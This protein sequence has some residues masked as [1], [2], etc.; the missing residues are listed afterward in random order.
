MVYVITSMTSPYFTL[1]GTAEWIAEKRDYMTLSR[2]KRKHNRTSRLMN[3]AD[4]ETPMPRFVKPFKVCV[5]DGDEATA[6]DLR[7]KLAGGQVW[8]LTCKREDWPEGEFPL[9]ELTRE[10]LELCRER[11]RRWDGK[12]DA[13]LLR[14]ECGHSERPTPSPAVKTTLTL[15]DR[16]ARRRG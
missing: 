7:A 13:A 2:H 5:F 16:V 1:V 12:T 15:A 11:S 14:L 8:N 10:F 9:Y 4:R 3:R 6:V